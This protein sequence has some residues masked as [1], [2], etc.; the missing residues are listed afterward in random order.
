MITPFFKISY[1]FGFK[2]YKAQFLLT[3]HLKSG[4][5][6]LQRNPLTL[7]RLVGGGG[8]FCSRTLIF[9]TITVTFFDFE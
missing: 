7:N 4:M 6:D 2:L 1:T 3:F 8:V 9:D 5:S